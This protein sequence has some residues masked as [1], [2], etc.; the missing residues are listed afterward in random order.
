MPSIAFH[1]WLVSTAYYTINACFTPSY[2]F[3]AAKAKARGYRNVETFISII[4][5][6]AAPIQE[7]IKFP[8]K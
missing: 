7:L 3:Q 6:L 8:T 2:I 4:C 5:Q 1:S